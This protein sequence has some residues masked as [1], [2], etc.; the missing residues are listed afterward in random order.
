MSTTIEQSITPAQAIDPYRYGWRY[1]L[2]KDP[3]NPERWEQVPLTKDDVLHPNH[4]DY[5]VHG[6]YHDDDCTYLKNALLLAI[7]RRPGWRV[8]HDVRIDFGVEG[9]RPLCP[10][11]SVFEN[12]PAELESNKTLMVAENGARPLLMIEV[13]SE[14]TRDQDI[15]TKVPLYHR[16]GV[17]L[18]VIVD[19]LPGETPRKTTLI[20]YRGASEGF[21]WLPLN[22]QKRL[23]LEPVKLWIAGGTPRAVLYDEQGQRVPDVEELDEN[24]RR[25]DARN[26]ELQ[27]QA[28]EAITARRDAEAK[29]AEELQARRDAEAKAAEELLARRDA[30]AKAAQEARDREIAD[31]RAADLADQ[32]ACAPGRA[33]APSRHSLNA[34]PPP[35]SRLSHLGAFEILK[36]RAARH[37]VSGEPSPV[38]G[39]VRVRRLPASRAP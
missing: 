39:R 13:T 10:D 5:I 24:M 4:E 6:I 35:D 9:V 37:G 7:K 31:N 14:N 18:Y 17:P 38:R 33:S 12:V 36:R 11:I 28:E 21:I 22:P 15:I 2:S 19:Y 26:E 25:A 3:A 27:T 16:A 29:A 34:N 32:L 8:F 1:V 23:W 30:E 20:G